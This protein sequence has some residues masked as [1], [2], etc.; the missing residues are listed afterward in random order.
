MFK[1]ILSILFISSLLLFSIITAVS[2][3]FIMIANAINHSYDFMTGF[4][5]FSL[6][7]ILFISISI[8]YLITKANQ[9][10][11]LIAGALADL[12]NHT[13]NK[14]AAQSQ[15]SFNQFPNPQQL[16]DLL[17]GKI[18]GGNFGSTTLNVSSIDEQGNIS[19]IVTKT[20]DSPEDFLKHRD[21]IFAR[22]FGAKPDEVK[23]KID[24]MSIDELKEKEKEAADA[25]NWELAA[26]Y[27]DAISRKTNPEK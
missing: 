10:L 26:A 6:G 24:E 7:T 5:L 3:A 16:M 12:I 13:L 23:K 20:F 27:R 2:G 14:E 11:N 1:S 9:N 17:K 21:E 25:E 15:S 19:P 22:A 8:T 18:Q 4:T